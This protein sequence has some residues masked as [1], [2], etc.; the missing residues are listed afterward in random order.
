LA[1]LIHRPATK[2]EIM[3]IVLKGIVMVAAVGLLAGCVTTGSSQG[4]YFSASGTQE[5]MM[6]ARSE[7]MAEA[8]KGNGGAKLSCGAVD[9]CMVSRNFLK[10][11]KGNLVVP[12]A[13]APDC[14][15]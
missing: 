1:L 8:K 15:E 2:G 14:E 5:Q 4:R 11:E 6:K 13:S 9:S 10:S 3:T 7:C 12:E